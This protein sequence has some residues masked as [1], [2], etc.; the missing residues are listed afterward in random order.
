M[1]ETIGCLLLVWMCI[2]SP[3]PWRWRSRVVQRRGS[4]NHRSEPGAAGEG[5]IPRGGA[6]AAVVV[7]EARS[8]WLRSGPAAAS[9]GLSLRGGGSDQDSTTT[10][11]ADQDRSAPCAEPGS[12]ARSA[13][14][15]S[16]VI[17]DER[18]EPDTR[19]P[20]PVKMPCACA[21]RAASNSRPC[22]CAMVYRYSAKGSWTTA[23]SAI[24]AR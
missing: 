5:T 12:F 10:R 18:D 3:S 8:V 2:K 13:E 7:Y 6:R 1:D 9:Q 19:L 21:S 14:L 4:G 23:T 20:A 16:V 15:T 17:P 11:G 24:C 22:C